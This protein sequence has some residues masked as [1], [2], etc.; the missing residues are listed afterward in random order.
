MIIWLNGSFGSGKS[1]IATRLNNILNKS[2]IYAPEIIGTFLM[3]NL[4]VKKDDFQDYELWRTFNYDI[5]KYLSS[6]YETIIVP[7]T[8][9]NKN[10]MMR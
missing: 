6:L 4:P 3:D 8:I 1:T 10:I 5:L 9:T 7:M 2:I